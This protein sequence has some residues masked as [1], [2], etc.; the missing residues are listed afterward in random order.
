MAKKG[1]EITIFKNISSVG[2]P[3]YRDVSVIFERIRVGTD[4]ALINSI[5]ME[6][7]KGKRNELKKSLV[8][9]CF[10]G[11]FTQRSLSGLVKHS[12]LVC[13]DFDNYETEEELQLHKKAFCTSLEKSKYTMAC[14]ISPSGK[15]LKVIVKIGSDEKNHKAY[16]NALKEF[17]N[18]EHFDSSGSDLSRVCYGSADSDIYVNYDADEWLEFEANE[19]YDLSSNVPVLRLKTPLGIIT[20]LKKW[21]DKKYRLIPGEN[22]NSNLFIFCSAFNDFGIPKHECESYILAQYGDKKNQKEISNIVRSAYKRPGGTKF[23]E[24]KQTLELLERQLRSGVDRKKIYQKLSDEGKHSSE[25]VDN[26]IKSINDSLPVSEFWFFT[27]KGQCK[28]KNYKYKLFLEQ[29][30]FYKF[31]PDGSENFIF[32]KVENNMIEPVTS[33]I[34]KNFTLNYLEQQQTM[35]PYETMTSSTK[36]FK[37]DYLNLLGQKDITF[38][39][40]NQHSGIIYF[41]NGA[42]IVKT[43]PTEHKEQTQLGERTVIKYETKVELVDY[44]ALN[45]YVFKNNI[46]PRDYEEVSHEGCVYDRFINLVAGKNPHKKLSIMSTIGYLMHS[47]KTSANNKAVILNDETISDNPNGGAGKG[48]FCNALGYMKSMVVLDGKLFNGDKSFAYQLV[49]PDT[50]ILV[51][52]DLPRNF[53]FEKLF[54]VVTEGITLEKKNKDAIKLSVGKSP[55]IIMTTNYTIG[56]VGGS[57]ERRKWELEFSSYF[58]A[59]HTPL[60]EFGHMLFDEWDEMEWKRFDCFMIHC[61]AIYLEQGLVKQDFTNLAERKFIKET[62]F[63]FHEWVNEEPLKMHDRL[64]KKDL[65]THFV[66]EY[67]DYKL[68][69]W[70]TQKRFAQWLDTY[71]K[72]KGYKILQGK[73][74]A[75]RFITYASEGNTKQELDKL[76]EPDLPEPKE[77]WEF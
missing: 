55:K 28:I 31:Y 34:I 1:F 36:M 73:D 26:A 2:T 64:Y 45:G 24:D 61:L 53:A 3:F 63:D 51:Y 38:V 56:G 40:D 8:S 9:I 54:S 19:H 35:E 41:Q 44:L 47:F 39:E 17:Y 5:R 74:I 66:E 12:G 69:K 46:I 13:L 49:G 22:V 27:E 65:F 60:A 77:D 10:S 68:N 70:F 50:S 30:G 25:E 29:N 18:N 32:V 15:G 72:Y 14:F 71:G 6:P 62:S 76:I 33:D 58:S 57:F 7:D 37:D 48:I 4:L 59:E 20:N 75:G 67:P 21:F 16:F 43:V 23:F 11:R 42:A 52:D